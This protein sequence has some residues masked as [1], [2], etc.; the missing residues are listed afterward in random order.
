MRAAILNEPNTPLELADDVQLDSPGVGQVRV[1]VVAC[2]ICHSD[3][4]LINGTFPVFGPTIPGHEAAGVVSE[5]G[6]GVESVAVG[7]HVVCSP[8]PACGRCRGCR[9]GR[10]G[11]CE[12]TGALMTSTFADGTTK[13]S[14]GGEV[15]YRGVGLAAWAEEV[16]V[17]EEGA[18]RI[19]PELPLDV[20]CVIGCAVQTGVGAAINTADIEP[21]DAVLV[22][23][24]GGIGVSIAAGASIAGA[25]HVI[26]SDPSE[27][28]REQAM[29]FGAT[30]VIDPTDADVVARVNELVP[31]GVDAA[32][33]AVG[34]SALLQNCLDATCAGGETV[35]V[36]AAPV[37]D[38]MVVNPVTMM[39][40]EKGLKGSLLGSSNS[41]RDIPRLVDLWQAGRL[42]LDDMVTARRPLAEI[43]DAV[44]DAAA[45]KGLRTVL[46]MD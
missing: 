21:G 23:G 16:I 37:D 34:S 24:A 17:D 18:I 15:V 8:N 35:M 22:V 5:V 7:D 33:D 44:A 41:I 31:G 27:S 29:A 42:P 43:N 9:R 36:G 40:S 3:L 20:A 13:L 10:P 2:G 38:N 4:S 26:V 14:R 12:R 19:A 30:E 1:K 45:G 6:P 32:F 39:F 11:A 28:R 25:S 46:M